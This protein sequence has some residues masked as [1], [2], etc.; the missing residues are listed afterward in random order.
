MMEQPTCQG[1]ATEKRGLADVVVPKAVPPAPHPG[2]T[3]DCGGRDPAVV[4]MPQRRALTLAN[5]AVIR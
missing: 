4:S 3:P 1:E 5:M 2:R